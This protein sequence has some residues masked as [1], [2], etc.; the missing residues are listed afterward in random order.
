MGGNYHLL[1]LQPI[2]WGTLVNVVVGDYADRLKV[3]QGKKREK[4][5]LEKWVDPN[6]GV[7]F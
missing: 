4:R 5:M 7:G 2:S 3:K 6:L 1:K